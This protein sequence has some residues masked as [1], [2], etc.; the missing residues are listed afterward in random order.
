MR[1][2]KGFTL[3]EVM[4]ALTVFAVVSVALVRNTMSSLSQAAGIRDK[5]VA[6]WIA[7][8]ELTRLRLQPRSEDN[9]PSAGT[10]R[11]YVEMSGVA[12][13]VEVE[14]ETTENDFIRRATVSV[15]KEDVDEPAAV[16]VGFLGR[17]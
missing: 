7:E 9:F 11:D 6:M 15:L 3:I 10:G 5:T 14:I 1:Q 16:L 4:I 2:S 13:E 8:N 17:Y 12:W